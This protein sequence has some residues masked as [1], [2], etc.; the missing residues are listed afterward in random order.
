VADLGTF[1]MF[2]QTQA[3]TKVGPTGQ[4]ISDSSAIFSG[5][6]GQLCRVLRH[7]KVRLVQHIL[8][9]LNPAS[10]ISK[11]NCVQL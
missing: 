9:L 7:S 5:L 2:G 1:S 11:Q 10:C 4:R 8:R 6:R 3:L